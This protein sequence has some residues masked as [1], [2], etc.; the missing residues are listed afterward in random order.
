MTLVEKKKTRSQW[1]GDMKTVV[2]RGFSYFCGSQLFLIEMKMNKIKRKG[3][4]FFYPR[5]AKQTG[6][7]A[8]TL[9]LLNSLFV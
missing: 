1:F 8:T 3:S 7:C 5:L 4:I 6:I 2:S 9:P